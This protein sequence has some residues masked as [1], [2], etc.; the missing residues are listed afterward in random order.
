[1]KQSNETLSLLFCTLSLWALSSQAANIPTEAIKGETTKNYS[2]MVVRV[3]L[4]REATKAK[5]A[6]SLN[7]TFVRLDDG[8]P[9]QKFPKEIKVSLRNIKKKSLIALNGVAMKTKDLLLRAGPHYSDRVKFD[10]R[11]YRGALKVSP[12]EKGFTVTNV[13]PLDEYLAGTLAAEMNG[14]WEVEAL[15]AQ[16]VAS[17][18]YVLYMMNHPKNPLFDLD[19]ST[20]DQVYGGTG[21]ESKKVSKVISDTAGLY[22]SYQNEPVK[23]YFHSRCGGTTETASNVWKFKNHPFKTHVP[24]PYCRQQPYKWLASITAKELFETLKLPLSSPKE[25]TN[26]T[27][28][29]TNSGRVSSLKFNLSGKERVVTSDEL[30][31]LLGYTRIKSANFDWKVD[32]ERIVFE[33]KGNGH[34]VGMCQWGARHMAKQGKTFKEILAHYYP[35]VK[36]AKLD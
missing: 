10:E 23:A 18:T 15:K 36:I 9:W 28:E 31:G 2:N 1:M 33:G 27:A 11:F 6:S 16:A 7:G 14:D 34:G 13:L 19:R 5:V 12:D 29:K 17:R 32:K 30:R 8:R 22:L 26:L 35:G 4:E 25:I 3:L 21:W 24:C 20:Q